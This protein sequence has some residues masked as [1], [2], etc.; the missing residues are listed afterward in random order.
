MQP[1]L[2]V[3][4]GRWVTM[5]NVDAASMPFTRDFFELSV[6]TVI[7]IMVA[8]TGHNLGVD[9]CKVTSSE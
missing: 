5:T 8:G 7:C 4:H 3:Q 9:F 1:V 2:G 6:I